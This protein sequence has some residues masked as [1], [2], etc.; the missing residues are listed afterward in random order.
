MNHCSLFITDHAHSVDS[1]YLRLVCGMVGRTVVR[2]PWDDG[3]TPALSSL[4]DTV[5]RAAA[6]PWPDPFAPLMGRAFGRYLPGGHVQRRNDVW[7]KPEIPKDSPTWRLR[8]EDGWQGWQDQAWYW[9]EHIEDVVGEIRV[10]LS[11]GRILHWAQ[12]GEHPA[13]VSLTD[14]HTTQILGLSSRD[15][16]G[17][18]DVAV[19]ADGGI[20]LVECHEPYACGLYGAHQMP[21]AKTLLGWIGDG[22]VWLCENRGHRRN[23]PP[24]HTET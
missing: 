3:S 13:E 8:R 12:Y 20:R 19:C 17:T 6:N 21:V 23:T 15:W 4:T 7:M 18:V 11:Y 5:W 14:A 22:W 10:Y 24:P 16:V 2:G 9:S 1:L